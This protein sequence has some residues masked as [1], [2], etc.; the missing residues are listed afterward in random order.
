MSGHAY[1]RL[2]SLSAKALPYIYPVFH[3]QTRQANFK[4]PLQGMAALKLVDDDR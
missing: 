1:Q 3:D 4:A 2:G